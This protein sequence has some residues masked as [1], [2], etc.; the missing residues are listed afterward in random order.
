MDPKLVV[1]VVAPLAA[2]DQDPAL[3]SGRTQQQNLDS[4]ILSDIKPSLDSR[5]CLLFFNWADVLC[6]LNQ[7]DSKKMN[8]I[9][10]KLKEEKIPES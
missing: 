4:N 8:R 6:E 5:T 9:L 3:S 10:Q 1:L 2:R 7:Q